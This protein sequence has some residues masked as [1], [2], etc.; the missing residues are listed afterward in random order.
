[1]RGILRLITV[2]FVLVCCVGCDQAA[3][4]VAKDALAAQPPVFLLNGVVTLQYAEN[5]GAFL[6]LGAGL[7]VPARVALL[8]I[9]AG[10]LL[11]GALVYV[12]RSRSLS[13]LQCV[14]LS[15]VAGGGLGNLIDR[16]LHSGAVVDF[17]ILS[18]GPLHT[19]I[20][21]VADVVLVAGL[22]L[23]GLTAARPAP[24]RPPTV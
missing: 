7:P 16:L 21:N 11:A 17:V 5:S 22:L 15:L 24:A 6:R 23:F 10:A 20:F 2:L 9:F 3:K 19:G 18:V 4:G 1:M 13:L 14:A 12:L 8:V